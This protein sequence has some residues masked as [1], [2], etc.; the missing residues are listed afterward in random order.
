MP[1]VHFIKYKLIWGDP[2]GDSVRKFPLQLDFR[3]QGCGN[4][5]N[6]AF[7]GTSRRLIPYLLKQ[8]AGGSARGKQAARR[9]AEEF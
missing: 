4:N 2:D 1:N 8:V 5:T 6:R 3:G 9:S 7:P